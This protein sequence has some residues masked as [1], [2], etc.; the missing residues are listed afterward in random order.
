MQMLRIY[1]LFKTLHFLR[2]VFRISCIFL[3]KFPL[4]YQ[5]ILSHAVPCIKPV[6]KA[7]IALLY[8]NAS[9]RIYRRGKNHP[10]NNLPFS[11][12]LSLSLSLSLSYTQFSYGKSFRHY[13]VYY[14][15]TFRS[16]P[17]KNSTNKHGGWTETTF[18]LRYLLPWRPDS[19]IFRVLEDDGGGGGGGGGGARGRKEGRSLRK[20]DITL[21]L[22]SP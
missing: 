14:V 10:G 8:S 21:V 4:H 18:L 20:K 3:C 15:C 13:R 11:P 12:S 2:S 19:V 16:K 17:T 7:P 1:Q 9:T 6:N 22:L 5:Y